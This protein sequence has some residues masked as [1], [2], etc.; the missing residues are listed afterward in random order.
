MTCVHLEAGL[1]TF[2][3]EAARDCLHDTL[4][5]THRREDTHLFILIT[6]THMH[7]SIHRMLLS[8]MDSIITSDSGRNSPPMTSCSPSTS[9]RRHRKSLLPIAAAT[10]LQYRDRNTI[11]NQSNTYLFRDERELYDSNNDDVVTIT[12]VLRLTIDRNWSVSECV[13]VCE[14]NILYTSKFLNRHLTMYVN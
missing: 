7:T 9:R 2:L 3:L 10:S 12:M 1:H 8:L 4:R 6:C 13:S 5:V 14:A 11:P